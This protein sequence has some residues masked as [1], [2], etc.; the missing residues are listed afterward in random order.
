M[1]TFEEWWEKE[2]HD[3]TYSHTARRS[4]MKAYEA[5]QQSMLPELSEEEWDRIEFYIERY[6]PSVTDGISQINKV[7]LK[8]F[9]HALEQRERLG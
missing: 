5:G 9:K 1:K 7:M 8:V 4:S 2:G 3:F 6:Y